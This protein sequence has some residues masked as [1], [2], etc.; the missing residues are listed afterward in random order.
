[1]KR[2]ILLFAC[3][4]CLIVVVVVLYD[5]R[6][7]SSPP[8][9]TSPAP[10]KNENRIRQLTNLVADQDQRSG[11]A[12]ANYRPRNQPRLDDLDIDAADL[13]RQL[14][15]VVQ[16]EVRLQVEEPACRIVHLRDWHFVPKAL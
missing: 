15:G 10:F 5:N 4:A 1:M 7:N 2:K 13:L 11:Q 6:Q 3:L 8:R 9:F 14:P 12:V 16:V